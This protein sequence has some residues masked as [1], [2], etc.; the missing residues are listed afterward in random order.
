MEFCCRNFVI[1]C[2]RPGTFFKS[3]SGEPSNV[4]LIVPK[5]FRTSNVSSLVS[6]ISKGAKSCLGFLQ[7]S[8]LQPILI[9]NSTSRETDAWASLSGKLP[10]QLS[11]VTFLRTVVCNKLH[12]LVACLKPSLYQWQGRPELSLLTIS[13]S[14]YFTPIFLMGKWCGIEQELP[15][16]CPWAQYSQYFLLAPT[17]PLSS[18][19]PLWVTPI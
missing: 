17:W 3:L 9:H 13:L 1:L 5:S 2:S 15:A 6:E 8:L 7:F 16:C 14:K 10:L 12:L 19:C 18:H 11:K 4:T